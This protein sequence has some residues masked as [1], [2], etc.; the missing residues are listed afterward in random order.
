M[1]LTPHSKIHL[2]GTSSSLKLCVPLSS[3]PS[4]LLP[5]VY[6]K[7]PTTQRYTDTSQVDISELWLHPGQ[8]HPFP[9]LGWSG[10]P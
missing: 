6:V 9:R 8:D 3:T 5:N 1:S 2:P 7:D 10:A 4:P